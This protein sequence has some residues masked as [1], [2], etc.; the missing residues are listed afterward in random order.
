MNKSF[1]KETEESMIRRLSPKPAVWEALRPDYPPLCRRVAPGPRY[2][3]CLV[4]DSL[5]FIPKGIKKVTENGII[6]ADGVFRETDAIVCAT[7][8]DT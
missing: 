6:D 1:S 5:N 7:G 8:F 4:D 3:E 2:L